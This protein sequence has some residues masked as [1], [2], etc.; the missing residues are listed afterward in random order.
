MSLEIA[1]RLPT[2]LSAV[3]WCTATACVMGNTT[4]QDTHPTS[5]ATLVLCGFNACKSSTKCADAHIHKRCRGT[6]NPQV[7]EEQPP[8]S[9]FPSHSFSYFC[10]SYSTI[11]TIL[12][13]LTLT[14]PVLLDPSFAILTALGRCIWCW[15]RWTSNAEINHFA[16][17]YCVLYSNPPQISK[18]FTKP[19]NV[20]TWEIAPQPVAGI[21]AHVQT[22]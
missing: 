20:T 7:A 19:P 10:H 17:L 8:L 2:I 18:I 4:G 1:L 13:P 5:F 11:P 9:C 12:P 22:S 3:P 6:S 15:I 16:T 21:D 14:V